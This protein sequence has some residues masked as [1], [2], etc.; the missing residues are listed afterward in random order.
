MKNRQLRNQGFQRVS[1]LA[2][3]M[4]AEATRNSPDKLNRR[5]WE[6]GIITTRLYKTYQI[7]LI[8]ASGY[9]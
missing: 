3:A 5:Q 4:N 6:R 8:H 7:K 2:L 1:W 9:F